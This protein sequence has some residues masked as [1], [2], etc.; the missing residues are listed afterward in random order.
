VRIGVT[1]PR[2]WTDRVAI[3]LLFFS[4]YEDAIDAG[5]PVTLI[6]GEAQGFDLMAKSVAEMLGWTIEPYPVPTWY[7]D[8]KFDPSAGH[9]RNQR[10]VD[11][12]ADYWIAGIMQCKKPE[13][14]NQ[15]AHITH[16]TQDC[17][18]RVRRKGIELIELE[19]D[20]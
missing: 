8:G 16:G 13:H 20:E 14:Y 10:M 5:E 6:E 17:I 3:E 12:G 7:P 15:S 1:G 4:L 9:K 11:T 2:T 18:I 19:T